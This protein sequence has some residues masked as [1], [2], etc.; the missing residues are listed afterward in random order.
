MSASQR[1]QVTRYLTKPFRTE[2]FVQTVQDV[3]DRSSGTSTEPSLTDRQ[4]ERMTQRLHDLWYEA[5]AH[6]V[7]LANTAGALLVRAGINEGFDA[8]ELIELL[9]GSFDVPAA[10][11]RQWHEERA[12]NLLY[13]EGVRFDLYVANIDAHLLVVMAFDRRQGPTRI[14]V[15][16]LYL[17]RAVQDLQNTLTRADDNPLP[18]VGNAL[19]W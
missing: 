17:K 6:S 10:L 5:G 15:V 4:L 16:W 11:A 12:I 9:R 19:T 14:G 7:L 8:A 18:S 3:L 2:E 1:L 13:H